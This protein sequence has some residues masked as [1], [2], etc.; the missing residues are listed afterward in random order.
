VADPQVAQAIAAAGQGA[1][2]PPGGMGAPATPIEAAELVPYRPG[3]IEEPDDQEEEDL[4]DQEQPDDILGRGDRPKRGSTVEHPLDKIA[5]TLAAEMKGNAQR[6]AA[7]LFPNGPAG[8][9]QM[10]KKALGAYMRRHWD[11]PAFRQTMLDRLAPKGPDG[12]RLPS[13]VAAFTRLYKDEVEPHQAA[14]VAA[15][16][17]AAPPAGAMPSLGSPA[18]STPPGLPGGPQGA[19]PMPLPQGAPGMAPGV[20]MPQMPGMAPVPP[21]A[22]APLPPQEPGLPPEL[23]GII[24]TIRPG[25]PAAPVG[26]MAPVAPAS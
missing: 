15:P 24:G 5:N 1:F 3:G 9:T 20:P 18:Q 26:P 13:G 2:T 6:M 19:P 12:K 4:A 25:G 10:S 23:A 7:D 11:D 14:P 16:E 8:S 22:P 17:V 21:Q